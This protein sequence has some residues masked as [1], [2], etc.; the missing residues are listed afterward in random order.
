MNVYLTFDVEIWCGGWKDL[1]SRFS[2]SFERYVYGHSAKGDYALPKTLEILTSHRLT[3]V[4]FVEPLFAGR[5][6]LRYLATIVDLI[7]SAGHDVQLHLH[8]EWADEIRPIPFPGAARKRQHLIYYSLEEQVTLLRLGLSLMTQVGCTS[9]TAFRAGSFAC[10]ADTYRALRRCGISVDSSLDEVFEVSGA[11]LRGRVDF[12]RPQEFEGVSILP[13]SLFRDGMG[14]LRHAQVGACSFPELRQALE[15]AD[16]A[17]VTDFT[18]LSHN[19]EM[20]RPGTT[21]PD[22]IVVRRFEALCAYLASDPAR[23]HVGTITA[24]TIDD[25]R[26]P[27]PCVSV[28]ATLQRHAEQLVRRLRR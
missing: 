4:F 1:D 11:D 6:G 20:L 12:T 22:P 26:R 5:F 19:F 18:I 24:P 14:R 2:K 9:L 7:R 17:G 28:S 23:F 27:M 21:E 13:I 3:G 10:N 8:P 16:R 25:V 15:A